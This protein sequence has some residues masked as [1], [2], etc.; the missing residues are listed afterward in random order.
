MKKEQ[1][2]NLN[3][4]ADDE[5]EQDKRGQEYKEEKRCRRRRKRQQWKSIICFIKRFWYDL[6]LQAMFW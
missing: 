2:K 3:G 6:I 1:D 4:E 5:G